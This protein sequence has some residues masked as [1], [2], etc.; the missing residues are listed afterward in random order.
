MI[1][2]EN[3]TCKY[4]NEEAISNIN[5]E[6]KEGESV[7]LIGPNGSGKSSFLKLINGLIEPSEGKFYLLDEEITKKKLANNVF[8]KKFHQKMGF[9]F[10][11]SDSQLFCPLV[12]EE[13]AFGP[14][15]MGL[16]MEEVNQRTLD[17]L[18]LLRI[19]H[20]MHRVPYHLSGGEKKK[21]AIASVLSMN[22]QV[23][24]M[25]EPMN[26]MDPKSKKFLKELLIKLNKAGKTIICATHDFEYVDG[27]F[28]RAIVFSE[29]HKIIRD[30]NYEE[31]ISDEEFLKEHNI[32]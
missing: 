21:V 29:E 27:I 1:R 28:E 14:F 4:D 11:N 30:G 31:I 16:S 24:I 13:V 26:G 6:I 12:Y 3:L 25:D 20:L 32:K 5:L 8:S 7:A 9:I 2:I 19:K 18:E 15:Q 17:S 23:I 10:Q 22:P